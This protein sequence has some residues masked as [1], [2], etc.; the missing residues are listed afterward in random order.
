MGAAARFTRRSLGRH[1][2]A[3]V[4]G[5]RHGPAKQSRRTKSGASLTP[6]TN[7][8]PLARE[9][10]ALRLPARHD[11]TRHDLTRLSFFF[12]YLGPNFVQYLSLDPFPA[13]T[14]YLSSSTQSSQRLR[15]KAIY[16]LSGLLKHNAAAIA[17]FGSAEPCAALC[18]QHPRPV[19][20]L[21]GKGRLAAKSRCRRGKVRANAL[22]RCHRDA[23]PRSECPKNQMGSIITR[24]QPRTWY[25]STIIPFCLSEILSSATRFHFSFEAHPEGATSSW[26]L[27]RGYARHHNQGQVA[28]SG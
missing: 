28:G 14:S 5:H 7:T 16:A 10:R 27:R 19:V 9:L 24:R 20:L 4:V 17:P 11:P 13:I 18:Q 15:S 22:R 6:S 21:Q 2:S 26:E 1:Q 25:P 3:G 8:L 12:L 23:T